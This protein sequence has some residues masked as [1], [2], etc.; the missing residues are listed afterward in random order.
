MVQ[1]TLYRDLYVFSKKNNVD[2]IKNF[3]QE[4]QISEDDKKIIINDSFVYSV[5]ENDLDTAKKLLKSGADIGVYNHYILCYAIKYRN[6]DTIKFLVK[7][8]ADIKAEFNRPLRMACKMNHNEIVKYLIENG[9]S[10]EDNDFESLRYII[11]NDNLEILKLFVESGLEISKLEDKIQYNILYYAF[12]VNKSRETYNYMIKQGANGKLFMQDK[13]PIQ[14]Y[15][16]NVEFVE[17][18]V[19]ENRFNIH[20]NNE[21]ALYWAV[22]QNNIDLVK[23]LLNAGANPNARNGEIINVACR[24]GFVEIL[25]LLISK[26]A[27]INNECMN[28]AIEN[29]RKNIISCIISSKNS[30][31]R[32]KCD[33]PPTVKKNRR[34]EINVGDIS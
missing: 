14:V 23:I 34:T 9:A 16:N 26:K 18:A 15:L 31:K 4:L 33:T 7:R 25:N 11:K 5:K 8:G 19:I 12:V 20:F 28:I 6:L 10:Y 29:G 21:E 1:D 2:E 17:N 30:N 22:Y 13:V 24:D 3:Y 32:K 27:K